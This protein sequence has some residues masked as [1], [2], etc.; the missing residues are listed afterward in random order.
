MVT[1]VFTVAVG[2]TSITRTRYYII[3]INIMFLHPSDVPTYLFE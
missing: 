2:V 3:V 1:V